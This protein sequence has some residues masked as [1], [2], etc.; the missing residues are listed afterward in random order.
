MLIV[1]SNQYKKFFGLLRYFFKQSKWLQDRFPDAELCDI[2]GLV[3][4]VDIKKIKENDWSLTPGR[5]V[6]IAQ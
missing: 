6:G 3:K 2:E 1:T 5:Y 4:L